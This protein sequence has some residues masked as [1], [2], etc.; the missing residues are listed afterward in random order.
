MKIALGFLSIIVVATGIVLYYYHGD[1]TF[2]PITPLPRSNKNLEK[3]KDQI[4]LNTIPLYVKSNIPSPFL[5][6]I[7]GEIPKVD[8]SGRNDILE[9]VRQKRQ[10]KFTFRW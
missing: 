3:A 1:G 10:D 7:I 6:N 9:Q 2:E 5:V 8:I 4:D